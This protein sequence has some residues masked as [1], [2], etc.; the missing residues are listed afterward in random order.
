MWD[1]EKLHPLILDSIILNVT[2]CS[3]LPQAIIKCL[4]LNLTRYLVID[5]VVQIQKINTSLINACNLHICKPGQRS[6]THSL[7]SKGLWHWPAHMLH[8]KALRRETTEQIYQD[9]CSQP[10]VIELAV[11]NYPLPC[12]AFQGPLRVLTNN[13]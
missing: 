7:I 13:F 12:S 8:C 11:W 2:C 3:T 4:K 9:Q 6:N 1:L 10:I 5:T